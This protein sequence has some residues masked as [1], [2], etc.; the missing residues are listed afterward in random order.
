MKSR[1][2]KT[3]PGWRHCVSLLLYAFAAVVSAAATPDDLSTWEVWV[4][5]RHTDLNCPFLFTDQRQR[6]CAWP[7]R[8][9]LA[10]DDRGFDFR[11][12]WQVYS[13]GWVPLPGNQKYWPVLK[14]STATD[15]LVSERQQRPMVWLSTGEHRLHGRVNWTKRPEFIDLPDGAGLVSLSLDG[16][17]Q[18][19]PQIDD[20]ARLWLGAKPGDKQN[21]VADQGGS[22]SLGLRVFRKLQD[23]VP[24]VVT[25]RVEL[26]VA[27]RNREQ[28][29]GKLL[30]DGF[31]PISINSQLPT[32]LEADGH[33]RAQLRPGNWVIE[34]VSHHVDALTELSMPASD[35][36]WAEQE[37]WV[38]APDLALRTLQV[39]GVA[40]IDPQQ[41]RLPAQWRNWNTY[42]MTGTDT[43]RLVEQRRGDP[44]PARNQ[45]N[46][47]RQMWLDFSGSG[48][49]LEDRVSGVMNRDWR[50]EMGPNYELGR[51]VVNSQPQ[52][53][54]RRPES[55]TAGVE[56]RQRQVS[57][58]AVSRLSRQFNIPAAGWLSDFD[59][60]AITLHL[61]PGWRLFAATGVDRATGTWIGSWDLWDIFLLLIISLTALRLCGAGTGL[62]ALATLIVTHGESGS[63]LFGWLNLLAAM[64]L[65]PVIPAGR[66]RFFLDRYRW[67]SALALV[68]IL[69]PF[70]V[71]QI[72]QGI[73]PQ[74]ERPWQS[75]YQ[76]QS[77]RHPSVA[78]SLPESIQ[79]VDSRIMS[80]K[81]AMKD[82]E[83]AARSLSPA[84]NQSDEMARRQSLA[85]LDPDIATQTGPGVPGWR[86]HQFQLSWSG[87]V[88][89]EQEMRLFLL[90]PWLNSGLA[91][92]R[93]LLPVLLLL[94][95][96][97]VGYG[98]SPGGWLQGFKQVPAVSGLAL[99]L[100][101][102]VLAMPA[103][104]AHA[105]WP[106][107]ELLDELEQRLLKAPECLPSC[108]V[109]TRSS[110]MVDGLRMQVELWID[111]HEQVII[112]LPVVDGGG[113]WID[114]L[115][116]DNQPATAVQRVG[117]ALR[118][119]LTAGSHRVV[120]SGR[121]IGEDNLQLNFPL[122]P[123]NLQLTLTGWRAA[124][125]VDGHLRGNSLGLQRLQAN[126]GPQV[127]A[128]AGTEGT[129]TATYIAPFVSVERTIELGLDWYV[130]TVVRRV[131]PTT[132]AINVRIP[133]LDGEALTSADHAVEGGKVSVTLGPGQGSRHWRSTLAKTDLLNLQATDDPRWVE[134]WVMNASP[135]WYAEPV[136][137]DGVAPIPPIKQQ[138]GETAGQWR[139]EW[140]PWP[141]ETLSFR[142]FRPAGTAGEA[143]TIDGVGLKHSSGRR[144]SETSM[145][146]NL[147]ASKGVEYPVQLPD[148]ARLEMLK[149][150]G[151]E[152]P[153][154]EQ[155]ARPQLA[156]SPGSHHLEVRWSQQQDRS[157]WMET[158]TVNLGSVSSNIDLTL[159]VPRDRWLLFLGG[160]P[161][162]PAL[163]YWGVL[164]VI[165]LVGFGLGRL[166]G[167]PGRPPLKSR[168]WML[169][170]LGMSTGTFPAAIIV[171]A[172]LFLLGWRE[173]ANPERFSAS[174]FNLIQL[175][176]AVL[177]LAALAALLGT[178][179]FG[180]LAQPDMGVVGNGSSRYLLRWY[181]DISGTTLPTAWVISL[182]IWVYRVAMLIWSL[183]L[184]NALI[185]WLRWGWQAA[186]RGGL[187]SK[188]SQVAAGGQRVVDGVDESKPPGTD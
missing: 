179:P 120:M 25:T 181:Q 124:G 123:H 95:L 143:L 83:G 55:T 186:S 89:A 114:D 52:L 119:V 88:T 112:P 152:Q 97:G 104:Q 74:L 47:N 98:R 182:P 51:V 106:S 37:F 154:N 62:L 117:G 150:D 167:Q 175:G 80:A 159:A 115:T 2:Y 77:T 149:L 139:P 75:V 188:T 180:L 21:P 5:E 90:P 187:W 185:G 165:L 68:L 134:S 176:L 172:W 184:A 70:G 94:A 110:V 61:P 105:Q 73:D 46:L 156:V 138:Q 137:R 92:G 109:I 42:R 29:F 31:T 144:Q 50:L 102:T 133:L 129:L 183:W 177:T 24:L 166:G 10:V 66:F 58:N 101:I 43:L 20:Q 41:T 19:Y 16:K 171:V 79:T 148:G 147:R 178:I 35:G 151:K 164:V 158:P 93:V 11:H 28:L 131:A 162:G 26:E 17:P 103:N 170:G 118:A 169:L 6:V 48:Y 39:E 128:N 54:T 4:A 161:M 64:A 155:Q 111:S 18:V 22:D 145:A 38:V 168:H 99:L 53:I 116:I 12:V 136:D 49:T 96:L 69:L 121:L 86:W 45:L 84:R 67:L 78:G 142:I 163:L 127:V 140:R 135:I 23:G 56:I 40:T 125:L 30:L 60:A 3:I 34:V 87:P 36:L 81:E 72:R 14:D 15:L 174:Q 44:Q 160:P 1:S 13:P 85:T 82:Y 146:I 71:D 63:P 33:L 153:I 173:Q 126:S 130:T 108:A 122:S 100:G 107:S 7:G 8:L 132:G 59:K 27:G 76:P 113:W 65:L 32:K 91:F 57:V 9:E 141:G 157:W